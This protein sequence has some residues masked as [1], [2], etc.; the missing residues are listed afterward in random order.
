MNEEREGLF[1]IPQKPN[2]DFRHQNKDSNIY[3]R[4]DRQKNAHTC[5]ETHKHFT[6]S[7]IHTYKNRDARVRTH[8][9]T[10]PYTHTSC[11]H[12]RIAFKA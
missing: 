3:S 9:L 2:H 5:T 7:N 1:G 4:S 12:K 8:T 10:H 11:S 6:D